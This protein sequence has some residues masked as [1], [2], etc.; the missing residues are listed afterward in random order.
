[1]TM[2]TTNDVQERVH[3]RVQLLH[4]REAEMAGSI[5]A[6]EGSLVTS[7]TELE[8]LQ[9]LIEVSNKAKAVLESYAIEQQTDLQQSIE[10]LCTRGLQTV[11]QERLEFKLEFKVLRGQPEV[12]FAVVSY[13]EDEPIEMDIPNSFGGGLAVVCAVLLRVIVLRYLVEQGKVEPILILD[14]PLA[15]LSPNYPSD[16]SDSLR[17]RMATFLRSVCDELGV[18]IIL[19][20]HEPDY[21]EEADAF[22]IFRGGLG[23]DTEVLRG[24]RLGE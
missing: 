15:A 12:S 8:R 14:E 13:V 11:F 19:V 5:S 23:K 24:V 2:T 10:S 17:T 21:G 7:G 22:H 18:Q 3:K 20:T 1:M 4:R 9:D 16:D 6:L